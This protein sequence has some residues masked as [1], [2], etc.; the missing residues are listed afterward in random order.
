MSARR[1]GSQDAPG[2]SP[3]L[4]FSLFV[5]RESIICDHMTADNTADRT[6][7]SPG[8]Q[9]PQPPPD[10]P[11]HQLLRLIGSGSYGQVWL[12]RNVMGYFRAVKVIHRAR[13]VDER[14]YEREF[15]GICRF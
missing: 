3:L 13:F 5:G 8:S 9:P 15:E 1:W 7:F 14:P 6:P 11:D 10:I 2:H 4:N 12:A